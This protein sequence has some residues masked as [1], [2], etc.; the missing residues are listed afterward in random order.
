VHSPFQVAVRRSPGP[1]AR[2]ALLPSSRMSW[3]GKVVWIT[4]A[5]S[6]IGEALAHAFARRGARLV[7]SARNEERLLAV[8]AACNH[9]ERHTVLPLDLA[10]EATLA[11]AV[12]AALSRCGQVDVLVHNGG[13]SQRSL[14]KNTAVAVDRRIVETNFFG[15]VILTKA[16]LPSMLARKSGRFVVISSLV[17]KFGTPLRSGYSASKHA[18][19]GFFESLRAETW[20]DGLR[21]TLVCPGFIR[22]AVSL[23]ALTG[24]GSPQG[25][26]DR[27]QERGMTPEVCAERIVRAVERGKDE[28]LVGGSER[29]AV[30]F[31]RFFPGLFSR[32]IRRVRVT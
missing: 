32:L 12:A 15:A 2:P 11:P 28:V 5:S 6:G 9:P 25:T 1:P 7:L 22:T 29:F 30:Y 24:D 4:G 3:D 31:K 16:L 26:L 23:N 14:V 19:H 10:D 27:A 13:V 21:V 8:Q 18:L 20:R 17:G